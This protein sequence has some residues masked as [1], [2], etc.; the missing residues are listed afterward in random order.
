MMTLTTQR[1][2]FLV[3]QCPSPSSKQSHS[4]QRDN[5]SSFT[6]PFRL[7]KLT[8]KLMWWTNKHKIRRLQH[9]AKGK[10]HRNSIISNH[11]FC[12]FRYSFRSPLSTFHCKREPCIA[13]KGIYV[14]DGLFGFYLRAVTKRIFGHQ[15]MTRRC[16]LS[17]SPVYC[18]ILFVDAAPN[19]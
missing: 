3:C 14:C 18:I 13:E 15:L 10:T 17:H 6:C 12:F 11:H 8:V 4:K 2:E 19:V 16:I 7:E 5:I 9:R 1:C